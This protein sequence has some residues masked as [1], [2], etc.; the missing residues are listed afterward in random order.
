MKKRVFVVPFFID[1]DFDNKKDLVSSVIWDQYQDVKGMDF[2]KN[3]G[4]NSNPN[5][6]FQTDEFLTE[7][8]IDVGTRSYPKFFHYDGD[9]LWDIIV[10]NDQY[11]RK[12]K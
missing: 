3:T 10:G 8:M 7:D 2:Y 6:V 11:Y 1:V 9:T 12:A 4:T 5:F